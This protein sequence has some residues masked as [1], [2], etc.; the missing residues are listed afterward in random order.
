M[1]IKNFYKSARKKVD[2]EQSQKKKPANNWNAN[3]GTKK[4]I[5]HALSNLKNISSK[6]SHNKIDTDP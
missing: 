4:K 2:E 6:R 5:F 1:I 3:K